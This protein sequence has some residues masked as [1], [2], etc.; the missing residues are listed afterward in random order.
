MGMTVQRR[1]DTS[2]TRVFMHK[3][4]DIRG[5]VS[6]KVSELGGDFLFEGTPLSAPDGGICHVIKVAVA[7]AATEAAGTTI[8]V[9]KGH[10]FSVGDIVLLSE[11]GVASAITAIDTD[12]DSTSDI[13]TVSAALGAVAV[14]DCIAEAAAETTGTDS[15]LKYTPFA[16]SGTGKKVIPDSNLDVDAWVIGVT[17]GNSLPSCVR[18]YLTGIINYD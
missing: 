18:G 14:G 11:G 5:G 16:L 17:K 6:V 1:A 7:T 9:K 3:V 12:S 8:T 10:H 4:A 15:A 13:I 2:V